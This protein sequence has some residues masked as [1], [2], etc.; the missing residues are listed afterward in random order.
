VEPTRG[1]PATTLVQG[2]GEAFSGEA[3]LRWSPTPLVLV[4][5]SQVAPVGRPRVDALWDYAR[6]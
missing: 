5:T 3:L 1:K 2:R 6:G 4:A